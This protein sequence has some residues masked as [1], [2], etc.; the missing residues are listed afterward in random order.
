MQRASK[1]E[2]NPNN[3]KKKII[4]HFAKNPK[5]F[6]QILGLKTA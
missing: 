4:Y 1:P 5:I 6:V 2:K 3:N